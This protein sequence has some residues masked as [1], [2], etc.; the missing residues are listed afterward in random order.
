MTKIVSR[1]D[2]A[3]ALYEGDAA[4]V[5]ETLEAAVRAR[6]DLRGANLHDANLGSADLRGAYLGGADL[7]GAY[8]GDADLGGAD[9]RGAYLRG[10]YLGDA[11]LGGAN[12]HDADLRGANL[13]DANLRDANLRDAYLGGANLHDANLGGA[14]VNWQSHDLI[15]ELLRRAAGSD[16][17]DHTCRQRRA[18]AGLVLV[19]RDWCWDVWTSLRDEYPDVTGWAVSVLAEYVQDGDGAPEV[20]RLAK[21]AA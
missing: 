14:T 13:R 19:S 5:R 6:A 17:A 12:L 9:L 10:A 21:G 8:L 16:P 20:L 7:R 18:F 4:T 15:A 1:W 3:L 11:D 2:R